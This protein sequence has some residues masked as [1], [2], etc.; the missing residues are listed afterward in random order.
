M[1]LNFAQHTV[2]RG[3]NLI[4]LT[5]TEYA[6]LR[7]L[8]LNADR[9]VLHQDLLSAVWGPEYQNDIDYLR[10]YIRYLRRKL[11][12]DPSNPQYILTSPG[13]GY[14]LACAKED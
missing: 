2:K 7:Q 14:M 9:V 11:E 4:P 8:A 10:A 1:E 12:V 5:P 6:L 13:V 3:G